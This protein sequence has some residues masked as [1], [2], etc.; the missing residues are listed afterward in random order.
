MLT[1]GT[2]F[3]NIQ[4]FSDKTISII[5]QIIQNNVHS[6][7][8]LL[9]TNRNHLSI[10]HLNRQSMSSTFDEFQV[11]L[12][13]HPFD[14]ITLSETWLR[15]NTNLTYYSTYKCQDIVSIIKTRPNDEEVVSECT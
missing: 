11:M 7:A 6:E 14:I 1:E 3:F 9:E 10:A 8:N 12:Y 2:T 13:Q 15:N 5:D 4:N